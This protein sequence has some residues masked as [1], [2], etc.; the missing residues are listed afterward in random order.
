MIPP[1]DQPALEMVDLDLQMVVEV[2]DGDAVRAPAAAIL[3]DAVEGRVEGV[4]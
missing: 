4:A 3:P 2:R 1:P